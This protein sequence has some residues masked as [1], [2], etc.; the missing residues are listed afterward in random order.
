MYSYRLRVT[1]EREMFLEDGPIPCYLF[2]TENDTIKKLQEMVKK[3]G[4]C[5]L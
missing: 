1:I 4:K 3:I 2:V 5:L